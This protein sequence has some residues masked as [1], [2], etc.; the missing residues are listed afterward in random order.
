MGALTPTAGNGKIQVDSGNGGFNNLLSFNTFGARVA[1]ATLNFAPAST[2]A[3][4]QFVTAPAGIS[5]IIG[6]F[7]YIT[8]PTNGSIDFAAT[9]A[10]NANV[11][12]LNLRRRR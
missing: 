1:G 9:P 3:G 6:G 5:G 2:L 8:N 4:I 11:A 7:A 12:A 10:N